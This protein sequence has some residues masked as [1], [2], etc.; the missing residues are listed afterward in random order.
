MEAVQAV[1]HWQSIFENWPDAI[2]RRGVVVTKHGE[3]IPFVDFLIS[4]GLVLVERDGPDA[5]GARRAI[6][7]YESISIIKLATN[8]E[9]SQFRA[10]GFQPTL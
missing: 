1:G 6:V 3:S 9:L 10:M 7:G 2:Q 5:S 8:C 4:E